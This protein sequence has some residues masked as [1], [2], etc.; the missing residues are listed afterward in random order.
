MREIQQ[1]TQDDFSAQMIATSTGLS[2][3][4]ARLVHDAM[5]AADIAAALRVVRFFMR[6]GRR[7]GR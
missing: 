5:D 7:T 1:A 4:R 2:F 6:P 3:G